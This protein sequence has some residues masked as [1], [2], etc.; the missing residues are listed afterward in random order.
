ME[1]MRWAWIV[2]ATLLLSIASPTATAAP[3][4]DPN[5][6]PVIPPGQERAVAELF[7]PLRLGEAI[8]QAPGWTLQS[9]EIRA[10]TISV[11]LLGPDEAALTIELTHPQFGPA[12]AHRT[13]GFAVSVP[14]PPSPASR[15]ALDAVLARLE[16]NDDGTFWTTRA[17]ERPKREHR[18]PPPDEP[19]DPTLADRAEQVQASARRWW[20]DG[21]LSLGFIALTLLVLTAIELREAPRSTRLALLGLVVGAALLRVALS[22]NVAL[23][24]WPFSRQLISARM[25]FEGP[26]LAELEAALDLGPIYFS[27]VVTTSNLAYAMLT[28]LAVYVHARNLL[29]DPRA[30]LIAAA[31]MAVLPLHL[32]FSRSDV[33]FIPSIVLSSTSFAL[34]HTASRKAH[35]LG[36]WLAVLVLAVPLC[37]SLSV[38]P[39]NIIYVPLLLATGWVDGGLW[40]AKAKLERTRFI[41]VALVVSGATVFVGIPHLREQYASDVSAGLSLETLLDALWVL[42]NPRLNILINPV[43]TP[44]GLSAL[45]IWGAVDLHRRGRRRLLYFLLG[46]LGLFFLGHGYSVPDSMYMQARYHLHLVVPFVLLAACGAEAALRALG[47]QPELRAMWLRRGAIAYVLASPLIHLHAIRY[48]G[49]NDIQEWIFVHESRDLIPPECTIVE[50]SGWIRDARFERVG[51]ARTATGHGQRWEVINVPEPPEDGPVLA[52]ELVERLVEPRACL[53]WYAGLPCVGDLSAIGERAP[54]CA[55]IEELLELEPVATR[56]FASRPYDQDLAIGIRDIETVLLGL[57]R[58]TPRANRARP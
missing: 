57:Y 53:I 54:A 18:P 56:S 44:P 35:A 45:A 51:G 2:V 15:A 39:L 47:E 7:A 22:P 9:F 10:R 17:I 38:R 31:V 27:D 55:A 13:R 3:P 14:T 16:A 46:W 34:C 5:E 52:A 28:P 24:P 49:L 42:I 8:D 21:L 11:A 32:R 58:A 50:Y 23:A 37:L 26:A 33:A 40:R 25:I 29:D 12:V 30:A 19:D 1:H 20:R 41:A 43:F 4:D 6:G 48:V 36:G